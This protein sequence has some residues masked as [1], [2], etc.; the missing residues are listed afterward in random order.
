VPKWGFK[1]Y[2]WRLAE[3]RFRLYRAGLGRKRMLPK[4]SFTVL[5]VFLVRL[6]VKGRMAD[7]IDRLAKADYS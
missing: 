3:T 1:L 6:R 4:F 7:T 2:T 5:S